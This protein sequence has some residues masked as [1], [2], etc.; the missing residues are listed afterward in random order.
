[1][2]NWIVRYRTVWAFNCV[3]LQNLCTNRIFNIYVKTEIWL[4]ITNNGWCAIKPNLTKPSEAM[5]SVSM[6]QLP[7]L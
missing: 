5:H 4:Q 6:H 3:Y 2:L 7:L 1:M